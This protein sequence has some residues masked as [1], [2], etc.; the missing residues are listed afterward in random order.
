[1]L[2]YVSGRHYSFMGSFC[3]HHVF[4]FSKHGLPWLP[5]APVATGTVLLARIVFTLI[6]IT[7]KPIVTFSGSV[8]LVLAQGDTSPSFSKGETLLAVPYLATEPT[9]SAPE[10]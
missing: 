3:Q 8:A 5:R 4:W 7:A 9:T 10:D 6:L 2:L 1:M